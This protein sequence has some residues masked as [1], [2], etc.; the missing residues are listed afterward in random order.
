MESK[1]VILF[2]R[3]SRMIVQAIVCLHSL[4]KH[5]DGKVTIFLES[6]TYPLEFEEICR[7]LEIDIVRLEERPDLPV[8]VQK[9]YIF[10][11]TP[12]DRS[13]F[14]DL[15]TLIVGKIDE[16]FD[17][18]E[19]YDLCLTNFC[20]WK[21]SGNTIVGRI[22]RFKGCISEAQMTEAINGHNA[23]NTGVLSFRKTDN[24]INFVR[25]VARL[26]DNTSKN[27]KVFLADEIAMQILYP[28]ASQT[29]NIDVFIAPSKFNTSVK[30]GN[31]I[32]DK[33]VIHNH[34]SKECIDTK[35]AKIWQDYFRDMR[36]NNTLN[37]NDYLRYADKRLSQYIEAE[38]LE[39]GDL[40]KIYGKDVTIVTACDPIY[41][42][43]LRETF[44]NWIKYKKID[45]HPVIVYVNGMSL[46]DNR[47]DFL[48]LPNVKM[49]PWE[50][51]NAENHREEMLSAFVFGPARDVETDYWL[52]MDADGF[53]T[54]Y[55]P[56]YDDEMKKFSICGHKWGYSWVEHIKKLDEWAKGH[57]KRKLR[58]AKPMIEDGKI[59]GRRFYHSKKRTA[60][61]IQL[62]KT[63]FSKF[64]VKIIKGNKLP[65]PSHDTFM[66]YVANRFDPSSVG[67]RNFKRHYGFTHGNGRAGAEA[68]RE[69]L[70][71]VD[72]EVLAN[73]QN[74]IN[75]DRDMS[76]SIPTLTYVDS[77]LKLPL[78]CKVPEGEN[79]VISIME[80]R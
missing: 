36:K 51:E 77:K 21:S 67:T 32:E 29:H 80:K 62:H 13:L 79:I 37:I 9:S 69:K 18:L 42:E 61:F 35:N 4:R 63:E 6:N 19:S 20:D 72:I 56:L 49:I 66:Y 27:Q 53:A 22:K 41:V 26:A 46:N 25:D 34:G 73:K 76:N 50:M 33:R 30:Y 44:P 71:L 70:K 74:N 48:R 23:I 47:L 78:I 17:Y 59:E 31:D 10:E 75:L 14:I 65:C 2:N 38:K 3:G 28:T 68:I 16:M 52:K 1:G 7:S 11:K 64:C 43:V 24:L 45:E 58:K 39:A 8:L 54:D 5:Y 12:Y 55:K 15:D 40:R 60:S 57:W